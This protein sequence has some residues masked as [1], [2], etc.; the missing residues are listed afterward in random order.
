MGLHYDFV[1]NPLR[2]RWG[3]GLILGYVRVLLRFYW[4]SIGA[5]LEFRAAPAGGSLRLVGI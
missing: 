3:F 4:S 1:T 5:L 2:F